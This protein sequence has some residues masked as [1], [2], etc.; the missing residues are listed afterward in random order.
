MKITNIRATPVNIP[1]EAPLCWTGG[2]YPGASKAIM[3]FWDS[4][5]AD[6]NSFEQ[7]RD[8]GMKDAPAR[9][10]G[11]CKRLLAEYEQPK[12]DPAIDEVLADF[13]RR[14]KAERP[15]QWR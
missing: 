11:R 15:D 10:A 3:A 6:N 9:A 5:V 8:K 2:H 1:L 7:W 4:A 14:R 12:L 13:G